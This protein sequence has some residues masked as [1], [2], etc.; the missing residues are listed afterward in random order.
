MSLK[1]MFSNS[2]KRIKYAITKKNIK[3]N[4]GI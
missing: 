4:R 3:I 1:K 2:I